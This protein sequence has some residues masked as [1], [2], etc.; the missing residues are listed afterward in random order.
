M[1]GC[2]LMSDRGRCLLVTQAMTGSQLKVTDSH[3]DN[4]FYCFYYVT[5]SKSFLHFKLVFVCLEMF[6]MRNDDKMK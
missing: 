6:Q 1:Q 4:R 2:V 5:L 3:I